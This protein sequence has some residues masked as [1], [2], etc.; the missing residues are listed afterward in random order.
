MHFFHNDERERF[1]PANHENNT[2]HPPPSPHS[3]HKPHT[4]WEDCSR[5]QLAGLV[6]PS[7][8]G[9]IGSAWST[10]HHLRLPIKLLMSHINCLEACIRH[11]GIGEGV[12]FVP[13][14]LGNRV[15]ALTRPNYAVAS[16]VP[17]DH[18]FGSSKVSCRDHCSAC[19][20][21]QKTPIITDLGTAG[22]THHVTGLVLL[23]FTAGSWPQAGFSRAKKG[24][25]GE[26]EAAAA[27]KG[28][29]YL[30]CSSQDFSCIQGL[31]IRGQI[32]VDPW[33][34][35]HLLQRTDRS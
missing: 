13:S 28:Y 14:W 31:I 20:W 23:I 2:P 21:D 35:A 29:W 30:L 17:S 24:R 16:V 7:R 4:Q 3:M 25:E 26:E 22:N 5:L 12:F 27:K 6:L 32:R 18:C 10:E 8:D 9:S 11:K 15:S 34:H 33:Q 1:F 19:G